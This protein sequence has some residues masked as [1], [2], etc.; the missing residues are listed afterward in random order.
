MRVI[1]LE[2]VNTAGKSS[3]GALLQN[4]LQNAGRPCLLADPAGFGPIGKLLRE[5]IVQPTF[6]ANADLDAVLFTALRAE[7]AQKILEAVQSQPSVT[8]VLERWSLALSAYG[9]AD[10]AR[11]Q[12]VSELRTALS[13]ALTV[14]M[15]V[16]LDISGE[17]AFSR[18][19]GTTYHNRFELRGPRYLDD[20]ARWYRH[21]AGQEDGTEV[22]DAS[23]SVSATFQRL[24]AV[25]A[26]KWTECEGID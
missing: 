3:V 26:T 1:A 6:E 20:V 12:L 16:L 17:V 25:L 15:T 13:G 18:I 10:G 14:D 2:G 23:G 11:H 5:R 4:A 19:T 7:G 22:I 24:R 21:F 9:A 8:V